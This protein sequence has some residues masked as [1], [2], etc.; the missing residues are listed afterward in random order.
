MEVLSARFLAGP[1][2]HHRD[3]VL[4]LASD[5]AGLLQSPRSAVGPC[6]GWSAGRAP[7]LLHSL[8]EAWLEATRAH[9]I[10]VDVMLYVTLV[11]Q[12]NLC[13]R[14][15][16]FATLLGSSGSVVR[17]AIQCEIPA[18]GIA[19]W[20][21]A[22]SSAALFLGTHPDSEREAELI[23]E[24]AQRY[25]NFVDTAHSV[26]LDQ[27]TLAL[28]RAAD[29]RDIPWFRLGFPH[30]LI[31]LGQGRHGRRL[32]ET[33]LETTSYFAVR[34][35]SNKAATHQLLQRL[36][37]PQPL[38]HLVQ[39][40][41][42]AVQAAQ[43]IGYPV[44]VKPCHGGKGR[45]VSVGLAAP[46]QVRQACLVA[47]AGGDSVVVESLVAGDDH[48]LLVVGG[49][50]I[51]GA[52]RLPAF[53]VG[54]GRSTVAEL[55][56]ELNRDPR[57]GFGYQKLME[58]VEIDQEATDILARQGLA[59]ASI[60][61]EHRRVSLRGTANVSRGGTAEDVTDIMH[62]D[63]ARLA[64]DVARVVGLDVAG[65]DFLTVDIRRSWRD[66][67]GGVIEVNANP[68]LRPHW[69]ANP[70]QRD[71]V[72]PILD[73]LAPRSTPTR[74]PTVAVT[75]S[76]G[77]TTTCRMVAHILAATGKRVALSTTQGSYIDNRPKHSG[78]HAGGIAASN[79][80]LHPDVEAGVFEMARG[81]LVR[82]GMVVDR[83]D[84]G[85]VLN[86]LDNHL[87]L[88]GINSREEM[89][90]VKRIIAEN[91]GELVVLNADDPLCLAMRAHVRSRRLCLFS[92]N[93]Q[94]AEMAA[95]RASGGCTASIAGDGPG[96]SIVLA[97]GA[98]KVGA[99]DIRDIPATLG[100][101]AMGKAVN[102]AFAL[103]LAHGLGI[104]FATAASALRGF[105]STV[106][107]NPGRLNLLR[108]LPFTALL[109]WADGPEASAE[110][111]SVARN[112]PIE[113]RRLLVLTAVGN[114]P[115]DFIMGAAK[116][117]AGKF[118]RYIC[119]NFTDLRGRAADDVPALL[120][121]GLL[122]GGAAA[123]QIACIGDLAGAL[124]EAKASV[125]EDDLLVVAAYATN[126][127]LGRILPP[128]N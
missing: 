125:S 30:H 48:R 38:Q 16:S 52:R 23:R 3:S 94:S 28:L 98:A 36:G 72:G 86:V 46:E 45:G 113:G 14:P 24:T 49:R 93:P 63:N 43:S 127:V 82:A 84:V 7:A 1:N 19:A 102:A 112:L 117:F 41:D 114:R 126:L 80:L 115:D 119:S 128:E 69:I 58:F 120:R 104:P 60:L 79:L 9:Q 20:Q 64:E 51:A 88:D 91:C 90:R 18:V 34:L 31:Q 118:D 56:A 106:E 77:K 53:V 25:R 57:R 105:A 97:E 35:T 22:A 29:Q 96:A 61:A 76:I 27:L 26:S 70:T 108:N 111:A 99:L 40:A 2:I 121:R 62:P 107:T 66:V 11:L 32:H 110:L 47:A 89:A 17:V 71:V 13:V 39:N 124:D 95:H 101:L 55:V 12:R 74:I 33:M 37:F 59:A 85:A 81:G 92:R 75:G 109:D 73:L 8:R 87:G 10:L 103:A 21:M 78:D 116:A 54:N 42:Q 15:A 5:L 65:I 83:F 68:G 44:V 123:E 100:G 122:E 4:V 6:A 67:G 50:L